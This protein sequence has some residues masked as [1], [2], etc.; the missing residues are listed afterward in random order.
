MTPQQAAE[1]WAHQ[2]GVRLLGHLPTMPAQEWWQDGEPEE[3]G[4]ESLK[5]T[6]WRLRRINAIV[7][8][9]THPRGQRVES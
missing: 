6:A 1:R 2:R 5:L 7:Y 4:G 9:F 8:H 3:V